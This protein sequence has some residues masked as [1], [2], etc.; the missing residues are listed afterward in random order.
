MKHKTYKSAKR[1]LE[2]SLLDIRAGQWCTGSLI[3]YG[4]I[5][6]SWA[7]TGKV[8]LNEED[9]PEAWGMSDITYYDAPRGC[10]LGL[11][12]MY[13]GL[14]TLCDFTE[15]GDG[16][17]FLP[18][19]ANN[20]TDAPGVKKALVALVRAIPKRERKLFYSE[21][22]DVDETLLDTP[23]RMSVESLNQVIFTFNDSLTQR[24]AIYW[25]KKA[26]DLV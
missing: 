5:E 20:F 13:A 4:E 7:K 23:E 21:L 6:Q 25:F 16:Y 9:G 15:R 2:E 17:I 22:E 11:V 1:I 26:I 3:E 14:G 19:Y 10:A 8:I 18:R 12:S 24:R